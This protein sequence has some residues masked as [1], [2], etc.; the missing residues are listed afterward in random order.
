MS[1]SWKVSTH[2]YELFTLMTEDG[3]VLLS[4]KNESPDHLNGRYV[5]RSDGKEFDRAHTIGE[6]KYRAMINLQTTFAGR[7]NDI[8]GML[9]ACEVDL[10]SSL[11]IRQQIASRIAKAIDPSKDRGLPKSIVTHTA[12]VRYENGLA[13]SK[14]AQIDPALI[15]WGFATMEGGDVTAKAL[16]IHIVSSL[17]ESTDYNILPGPIE[18]MIGV[19]HNSPTDRENPRDTATHISIGYTAFEMLSDSAVLLQDR[20]Q[21]AKHLLRNSP[22]S[23]VIEEWATQDKEPTLM[24]SLTS[25]DI[26]R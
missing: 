19:L 17:R 3:K 15:K 21:S 16:S 12:G 5:L 13:L 11:V 14:Y 22:V 20:I 18:T 7:L 2:N 26:T 24:R 9:R 1:L 25:K 10:D 8:E 6:A 23:K 4:F